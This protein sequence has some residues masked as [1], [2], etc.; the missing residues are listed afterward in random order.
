MNTLVIKDLA[1]ESGAARALSQEEMQQLKG[2]RAI[3]VLVDGRPGGVVDD[4]DL[5]MA[6]FKGDIGVTVVN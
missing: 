3:S 2:G 6:I 4:F 5:Q 1:H